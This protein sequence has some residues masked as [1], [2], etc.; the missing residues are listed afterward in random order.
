MVTCGN[1]IYTSVLDGSFWFC[2]LLMMGN[3]NEELGDI[4]RYRL[5]LDFSAGIRRVWIPMLIRWYGRGFN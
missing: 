1:A 5:F 4:Y 3:W 2:V